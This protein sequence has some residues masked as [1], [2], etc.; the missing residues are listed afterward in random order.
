MISESNSIDGIPLVHWIQGEEW[1]TLVR[2]NG[3]DTCIGIV[4]QQVQL[5][6]LL[7]LDSL[8]KGLNLFVIWMINLE[9]K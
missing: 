2:R 7:C 1:F 3:M 8:E 4:Y 9:I 5:S 6:I